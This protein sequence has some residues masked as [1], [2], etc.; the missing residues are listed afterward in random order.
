MKNIV[1]VCTGNTCRSPMAEAIARHVFKDKGFDVEFHSCG[2][3][4][5]SSEPMSENSIAALKS[6]DIDSSEHI[7]KPVSKELMEKADLVLA[8]TRT[9]KE[10]L[11]E[12]YPEH[13]EKVHTLIGYVVKLDRDVYDPYGRDIEI[14]NICCQEILFLIDKLFEKLSTNTEFWN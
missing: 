14:Y 6:R 2:I 11:K 10:V 9:H 13:E 1:F 3:A 5:F 4:V 12:D 7:S 8:M